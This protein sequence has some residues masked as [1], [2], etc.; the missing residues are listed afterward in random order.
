MEQICR[1][2]PEAIV[3]LY[4]SISSGGLLAFFGLILA[5]LIPFAIFLID[6]SNK[7]DEEK[8]FAKVERAVILKTVMRVPLLVTSLFLGGFASLLFIDDMPC[9]MEEVIWN[10]LFCTT[11]LFSIITIMWIIKDIIIW[12]KSSAKPDNINSLCF[13]KWKQYLS[14]IDDAEFYETW[15]TIFSNRKLSDALQPAYLSIFLEKTRNQKP[16]EKYTSYRIICENFNNLQIYNPGVMETIIQNIEIEY[17]SIQ[18]LRSIRDNCSPTGDFDL[19]MCYIDK[20]LQEDNNNQEVKFIVRNLLFDGIKH[21]FDNKELEEAF[22]DAIPVNWKLSS[23]H[24]NNS[25]K[26]S[27]AIAAIYPE[28]VF[29]LLNRQNNDNLGIIEHINASIVGSVCNDEIDERLLADVCEIYDNPLRIIVSDERKTP[30][31][32]LI[33]NYLKLE[34]RY[35]ANSNTY[36][37]INDKNNKPSVEQSEREQEKN[38]LKVLS[39]IFPNIISD[40]NHIKKMQKEI[41]KQFKE[42]PNNYHLERL[43]RIFSILSDNLK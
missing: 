21:Y 38:T 22:V 36:Y 11:I 41:K 16:S 25:N 29:Y 17:T 33:E 3:V 18:L 27:R 40:G 12:I 2:I 30:E 5:L 28:L 20:R 37:I 42:Q 32:I 10:A 13:K 8:D 19:L 9:K 15:N 24:Q 1:S 14:D 39:V 7:T 34:P 23:I 26:I 43:S 31:Q 4:K 35:F 6:G